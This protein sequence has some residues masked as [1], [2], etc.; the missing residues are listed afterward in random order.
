MNQMRPES[1]EG[2]TRP[3]SVEGPSASTGS[4]RV[5][6][7]TAAE[8]KTLFLFEALDEDQLNWLSDHGRVE[9]RAAGTSVFEEGEDATCFF[10]LL[11]GTVT[12]SRRVENTEVEVV[13]TNQRGVYGGATQSFVSRTPDVRSEERRVG[14]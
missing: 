2:P 9:S 4:A 5:P 8:L 11:S 14:K 13:R 3:E 10:V 12:M 7:L 6:R 1:V